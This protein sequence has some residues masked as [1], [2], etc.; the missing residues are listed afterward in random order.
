MNCTS[1]LKTALLG[2]LFF[3]ATQ[4]N[5]QMVGSD[6][7]LKGKYVEVGIGHLG[8]YGSDASAPT[9][10]HPHLY[11][12]DTTDRLGFVADPLMTGWDTSSSSHYMGDYFLPGNPFEGWYLQA[13]TKRCQGYNTGIDTSLLVYRG[14][15]TASGGNTA[16]TTSG[17]TVSG[18]WTG[19]IDSIGISQVTTLD[20]NALFFTVLLLLMTSI[21]SGRLILITMKHGLAEPSPQITRSITRCPTP[22]AYRLLRLQD[23]VPHI[24]RSHLAVQILHRGQLFMTH[25]R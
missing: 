16:Y 2:G 15:T 11:A 3:G 8:Y 17:S 24:L 21:I 14:I 25:G 1:L 19:A 23:R 9:G 20:T 7:F 22:P 10:Y 4:A 5:A 13:G 18:T 6:V 12:G